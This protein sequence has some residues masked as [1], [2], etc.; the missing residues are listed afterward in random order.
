VTYNGAPCAT[1]NTARLTDA[2]LY[3]TSI[4]LFTGANL[5]AFE[6]LSATCRFRVFGGDCHCYTLLARGFTDLVCEAR[7]KPHDFLALS[8]IIEGAGGVITDWH[9]A[10][11]TLQSDGRVAAAATRALHQAAL[12]EL[13]T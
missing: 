7:L 8:P 6:R 12:A 4:D 2:S 5:A 9:G 13:N 10:P 3:A 1:G 11:L